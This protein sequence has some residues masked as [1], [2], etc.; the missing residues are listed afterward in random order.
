[1]NRGNCEHT[2][3]VFVCRDWGISCDGNNNNNYLMPNLAQTE[4]EQFFSVN[5]TMEIQFPK[6][7]D[8]EVADISSIFVF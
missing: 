4:E 5:L 7:R 8:T 3:A 6:R 1:M 2:V